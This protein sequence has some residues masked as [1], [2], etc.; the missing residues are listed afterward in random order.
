ML[1][2]DDEDFEDT[3]DV[4]DQVILTD[5]SVHDV[6]DD[7][8]DITSHQ[9]YSLD[10][11]ASSSFS[12]V[13]Q[14]PLL[15][16]SINTDF[17]IYIE[18]RKQ[19]SVGL[20]K[21]A[22]IKDR[23]QIFD[24][25]HDA[26]PCFRHSCITVLQSE[27]TGGTRF[28]DMRVHD[29]PG[30][31]KMLAL[32][33]LTRAFCNPAIGS[34]EEQQSLHHT[35]EALFTYTI[36]TR[37]GSDEDN[38]DPSVERPIVSRTYAK[39]Y[40]SIEPLFNRHSSEVTGQALDLEEMLN[41]LNIRGYRVWFMFADP[42][43]CPTRALL[44]LVREQ[45][46][47]MG[48]NPQQLQPTPEL[49]QGAAIDAA[50][51][52]L[53]Q[54]PGFAA[55]PE[56]VQGVQIGERAAQIL[57]KQ[58]SKI[59][60]RVDRGNVQKALAQG[61]FQKK[62][63]S[64][65]PIQMVRFEITSVVD[66]V[67]Y[68]TVPEGRCSKETCSKTLCER[69]QCLPTFEDA[70]AIA[71]NAGAPNIDC[72]NVLYKKVQE[73]KLLYSHLNVLLHDDRGQS[74]VKDLIDPTYH[75]SMRNHATRLRCMQPGIEVHPRQLDMS[76]YKRIDSMTNIAYF[77]T[78]LPQFI[79][80]YA[81]EKLLH[82][83]FMQLE[84]P[85]CVDYANFYLTLLEARVQEQNADKQRDLNARIL[86]SAPGGRNNPFLRKKAQQDARFRMVLPTSAIPVGDPYDDTVDPTRVSMIASRKRQE[87]QDNRVFTIV[88]DFNKARMEDHEYIR[89]LQGIAQSLC[90]EDQADVLRV[91]RAQ[92]MRKFKS[93]FSTTGCKTKVVSHAA[94]HLDSKSRSGKGIFYPIPPITKNIPG[95]FG[96]YMIRQFAHAESIGILNLHDLFVMARQYAMRATHCNYTDELY[97]NTSLIPHMIV[98]G[99]A[100]QGKSYVID[101][102]G[103]HTGPRTISMESSASARSA[104]TPECQDDKVVVRDE[105]RPDV[106]PTQPNRSA[107]DSAST[108]RAK[109]QM[110]EYMSNHWVT[111]L[112]DNGSG[113]SSVRDRKTMCIQTMSH[114]LN[115]L[116]GNDMRLLN[117]KETSWL[118]RFRM[119]FVLAAKPRYG[120]RDLS[121]QAIRFG[122][123][124]ID[125][126]INDST[127]SY[128]DW[129]K[130]EYSLHV[131][132]AKAIK[133]GALPY[134][135]MDIV[136]A[137]WSL[138][139]PRLEAK[140]SFIRKNPRA[141]ERISSD[142][143]TFT[144]NNA[145]YLVFNS[146]ISPI[147][148]IGS[149]MRSIH[150]LPYTHDL[151]NL[152]QPYLGGSEEIAI[153]AITYGILKEMFPHD[154][155]DAA[156]IIT[157]I[158]GV[159]EAGAP[160]YVAKVDASTG[161]YVANQNYLDCG[162]VSGIITWLTANFGHNEYTAIAMITRLK[163]MTM[164][165]DWKTPGRPDYPSEKKEIHVA[166]TV[167]SPN[168]F[169][170][171]EEVRLK[172]SS[173]YIS[174][175]FIHDA[176]PENL[177][178]FIMS[179]ICHKNIRPRDV[180]IGCTYPGMPF[181]PRVYHLEPKGDHAINAA[182][183][184][185]N[186]KYLE[187]A[188]HGT[189]AVSIEALQRR[190]AL[191]DN[192][193][194]RYQINENSDVES[195]MIHSWLETN[196]Y[197]GPGIPAEQ[198]LPV[199]IEKNLHNAHIAFNMEGSVNYPNDP[200]TEY[201]KLGTGSNG[202]SAVDDDDDN[203]IGN[204]TSSGIEDSNNL[205]ENDT[206]AERLM[207]LSSTLEGA[208]RK[209]PVAQQNEGPDLSRFVRK[210][211]TM[212]NDNQ[213]QQQRPN[214]QRLQ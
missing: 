207:L 105:F 119:Y 110:T 179:A 42:V 204:D 206:Y 61:K 167:E 46:A 9:V 6:N 169:S 151:L 107:E 145:I 50:V 30:R 106:D 170:T 3:F 71:V 132:V 200:I 116:N 192:N 36:S 120:A 79:F 22:M 174:K 101:Q 125:T 69:C 191:R 98:F 124:R 92:G 40:V 75:F 113:K 7:Y 33:F 57:E 199:N 11:S 66:I 195:I 114:F 4:P 52:Q 128:K 83:E 183:I 51:A 58:I 84:F 171:N 18:N 35:P 205:T 208:I 139:Y 212:T 62:E 1:S 122:V 19:F 178:E 77:T 185:E 198:Y 164:V 41:P 214:R 131:A 89:R 90:K 24:L 143:L 115:W 26:I 202:A 80:N 161:E 117:D 44:A 156:R 118:T 94:G 159:T 182:Y 150:D 196:A 187:D 49:Y 166:M 54:R 48:K 45:R 68:L 73:H 88:D 180:L 10:S 140:Y 186:R 34:I 134:P 97:G 78:P 135:C 76:E 133:C 176:D 102:V 65:C 112:G 55:L 123:G 130:T 163:A 16:E 37:L 25:P 203:D 157:K 144:I 12:S 141:I 93:N 14:M 23:R 81:P 20:M 188:L 96:N 149:D 172:E 109:E 121:G 175:Q 15:K 129:C 142:A 137:V 64:S 63:A 13:A 184:Q 104:N 111:E 87:E 165:C 209:R 211:P 27:L 8:N 29:T 160:K 197:L 210:R 28:C 38:E 31:M 153:Y 181:L 91:I 60:S 21:F 147:H 103:N 39:V 213:Q 155:W 2:D 201:R 126:I 154:V 173:L 72:Q 67:D 59:S 158:F 5:S 56:D 138:V 189:K 148:N 136:A 74:P 127:A 85:W 17:A 177:I 194:D 82:P 162:E 43:I 152:L 168:K 108:S 193:L 146:M 53:G 190:Q 86:D 95:P 32:M 100:G 47:E 70:Y 99:Y